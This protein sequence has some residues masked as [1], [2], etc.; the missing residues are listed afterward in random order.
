MTSKE[1]ALDTLKD[2]CNSCNTALPPDVWCEKAENY[3]NIAFQVARYNNRA[4]T[5]VAKEIA[6]TAESISYQLSAGV[7]MGI[8]K[9]LAYWYHAGW[10]KSTEINAARKLLD[11]R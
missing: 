3:I 9:A 10:L 4:V 7:G 11:L 6:K 8:Y 2:I 1:I 5:A